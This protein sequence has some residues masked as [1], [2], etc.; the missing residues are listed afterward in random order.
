[1][2]APIAAACQVAKPLARILHRVC[3]EALP[4]ACFLLHRA[5][6]SGQMYPISMAGES[7]VAHSMIPKS[8]K[9]FLDKIM[10]Q[11]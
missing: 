8:V 2:D 5:I 7:P 4:F 3:D 1:M 9:R 10:R 6:D 11:H